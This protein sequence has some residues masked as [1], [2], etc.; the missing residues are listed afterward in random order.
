MNPQ[1]E[2]PLDLG[3]GSDGPISSSVSVGV[4]SYK[5]GVRQCA[6]DAQESSGHQ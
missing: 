4:S 5:K 1:E 6:L 3:L 2:G